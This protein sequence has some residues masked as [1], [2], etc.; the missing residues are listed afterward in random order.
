MSKEESKTQPSC[1]HNQPDQNTGTSNYNNTYAK[2]TYFHTTTKWTWKA[3]SKRNTNCGCQTQPSTAKIRCR[4]FGP[5][6]MTRALKLKQGPLCFSPFPNTNPPVA[7]MYFKNSQTPTDE[8]DEQTKGYQSLCDETFM[9]WHFDTAN[10]VWSC[11][12]GK[13]KLKII[14]K[15]V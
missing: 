8:D 5:W 7:I 3:N 12:S 11:F 6:S 14:E 2:T 9:G 1:G 10:K 13:K 15:K 4:G